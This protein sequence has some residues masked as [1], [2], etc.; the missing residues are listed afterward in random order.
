[1][2]QV[3]RYLILIAI[4]IFIVAMLYAI[5]TGRKV[6]RLTGLAAALSSVDNPHLQHH[7]TQKPSLHQNQLLIHLATPLT[8]S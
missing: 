3:G 4:I 5:S 1:M 6:S 8:R 2:S 7:P